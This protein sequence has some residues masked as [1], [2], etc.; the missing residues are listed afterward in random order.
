MKTP[1]EGSV[2]ATASGRARE[3][4][5]E[6]L[7][8]DPTNNAF[9]TLRSDGVPMAIEVGHRVLVRTGDAQITVAVPALTATA[10]WQDG[11]VTG[12]GPLG[13]RYA[14]AVQSDRH[15]WPTEGYVWEW[16]EDSRIWRSGSPLAAMPSGG[17]QLGPMTFEPG[18]RT[19]VGL[20][21][22]EGHR[23]Y[24]T[25][26]RASA[27]VELALGEEGLDLPPVPVG[28]LVEHGREDEARVPPLRFLVGRDG[29]PQVCALPDAPAA[30]RDDHVVRREPGPLGPAARKQVDRYGLELPANHATTI[31]H[32]SHFRPGGA[33]VDGQN[34]W[35]GHGGPPSVVSR[36]YLAVKVI[37]G[38]AH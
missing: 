10:D 34:Q 21:T 6:G 9:L 36:K 11:S 30:D 12:S 20:L 24:R 35:V 25:V 37:C 19:M 17:Y 16:P 22:P 13:S 14:W 4:L 5:D 2:I 26:M 29:T 23:V 18:K 3:Y 32:Q 1:G 15:C 7:D 38:T 8:G 27:E 33:Q 28:A 31:I